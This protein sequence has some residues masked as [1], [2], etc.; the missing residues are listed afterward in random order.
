MQTERGVVT[1]PAQGLTGESLNRCTEAFARR[2]ERADEDHCA[3]VPPG[4][5]LTRHV[6]TGR[7]T[8]WPGCASGGADFPP[9]SGQAGVQSNNYWS[10]LE[11]APNTN[12]A[13]NFNANNG[14]QNANNKNNNFYGWAVRSG[15]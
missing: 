10:G 12:N 13:W 11:Y 4:G 8:R 5:G 15:E 2:G 1:Q 7:A 9:A 14:N 3:P 6:A